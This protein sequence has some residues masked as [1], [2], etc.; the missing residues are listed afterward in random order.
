MKSV[1]PNR[2]ST[3]VSYPQEL[4]KAIRRFLPARGLP[5]QSG[6]G[7]VRWTDRVLAMTAIL[8]AWD[9]EDLLRDAFASA[10]AIVAEMYPSRRRPGRSLEGFMNAL[11]ARS[12]VLLTA[13]TVSLREAV[14]QIAGRHW[15]LD[16]WV[17]M[18]VDGS[19]VECP[20]T[21]ANE[22]AFGCAGKHRT[23][24]QQLVTVLFHVGTGLL[25]GWRRGRGD[26]SERGQLQSML[27]LLP[28]RTLLL[29][30]AGFTGYDLLRTLRD[31]GHDFIV[32]VGSNVRLLRKLGYAAEEHGGLVY[33]WP[34]N[35]RNERPLVLRLVRIQAAHQTVCLLTSVLEASRLTDAALARL[36]RQRWGVE[37]CYRSLK[38]TL[39]GRKMR[40]ASPAAAAA[41]LDWT[42]AGLAILGAMAVES[43]GPRAA[44]PSRWSPAQALRVVR[45]WTV[46][47]WTRRPPGGLRGELRRAVMDGYV[48]LGA[49]AA[50]DWPHKKRERPPGEPKIR[51]ACRKE[52]LA[53]KAFQ[54]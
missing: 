13:V 31:A 42:L 26:G 37:V 10:R 24:P 17:V 23:T 34:R 2:G 46:R 53:A 5:L 19:R 4:Q 47:R 16:V 54:Q 40:S 1:R 11:V 49:K 45:R 38:Q 22:Q 51:T 9:A 29:A 52:R 27:G 48:R 30:D 18:G 39:G 32:R 14:R 3:C 44:A 50:R 25:W 20:R 36:Y 41:E 35:Y 8:M 7:R 12:D 33:L 21:A 28:E 6:D 43:Q 15:R